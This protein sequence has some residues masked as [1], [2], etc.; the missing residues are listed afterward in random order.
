M[1][2]KCGTDSNIKVLNI[3]FQIRRIR[4]VLLI[5][6]KYR[7]KLLNCIR[8]VALKFGEFRPYI[9]NTKITYIH[10]GVILLCTKLKM[11]RWRSIHLNQLK[12]NIS[13]ST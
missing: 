10:M 3:Y 2:T 9:R 13:V 12:L 11:V 5:K 7:V 6:S 8:R 1:I 4:Q